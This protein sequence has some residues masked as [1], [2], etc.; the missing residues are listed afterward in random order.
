[1]LNRRRFLSTMSASLI[2]VLLATAPALATD[3][4]SSTRADLIAGIRAYRAELD[5][6]VEFHVAA[7]SR[8]GADLEKRRE[9]LARGLV[10]RR[11]IEESE[12]A[13]E[14]A[15]AKLAGTRRE[16][17]VADRSLSEA[18]AETAET[19]PSVVQPPSIAQPPGI[20]PK[21]PAPSRQAPQKSAQRQPVP[22]LAWASADKPN[23][24][25]RLRTGSLSPGAVF[26]VVE[27]SV[28]V[29]LSAT[30][31]HGVRSKSTVSQGSAVAV[32]P[33]VALTNCH[34]LEGNTERIG[35][36]VG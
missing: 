18:L 32:T 19:P 29:L 8:A 34:V 13:L 27:K 11:D 30:S 26:N 21:P 10:T 5:R 20:A 1:M 33:R 24:P 7:V 12:R 6:L 2:A 15:E 25:A 35:K 14:A 3:Y 9:L 16:M 22:R 23:M 28:Y 17:V 4:R 36:Y 31:A